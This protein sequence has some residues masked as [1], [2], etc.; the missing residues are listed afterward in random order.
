MFFLLSGWRLP[1]VAACVCDLQRLLSQCARC[2]I[3]IVLPTTQATR[4]VTS[5]ETNGAGRIYQIWNLVKETHYMGPYYRPST[6]RSSHRAARY[7][8]QCH[9][10]PAL[11]EEKAL[12]GLGLIIPSRALR[13]ECC[14]YIRFNANSSCA[15]LAAESTCMRRVKTVTRV[16]VSWSL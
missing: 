5:I 3:T 13:R 6:L 2:S 11:G 8:I 15:L 10:T 1:V 7:C 9:A 12:N 14:E 4:T 16:R